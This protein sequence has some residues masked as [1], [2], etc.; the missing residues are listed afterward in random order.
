VIGKKVFVEKWVP[1]KKLWKYTWKQS[2]EE[3]TLYKIS[4]ILSELKITAL[5]RLQ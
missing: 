1:G 5:L 4:S 3:Y 2:C